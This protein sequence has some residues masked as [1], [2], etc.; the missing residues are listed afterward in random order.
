[1]AVRREGAGLV[2]RKIP[3]D[4]ILEEMS[5]SGTGRKVEA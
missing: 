1:M 2:K 5:V 4:R 3:W